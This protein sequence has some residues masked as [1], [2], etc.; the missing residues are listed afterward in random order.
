[1]IRNYRVEI[2]DEYGICDKSH[3]FGSQ[4]EGRQ[5]TFWTP[6]RATQQ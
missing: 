1:M 3:F 6:H 5:W 4:T 2:S